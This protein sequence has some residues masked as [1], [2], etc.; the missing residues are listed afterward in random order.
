MNYVGMDKSAW[1]KRSTGETSDNMITSD[2][3]SKILMMVP[4]LS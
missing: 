4:V 3:H 2:T 1:Q